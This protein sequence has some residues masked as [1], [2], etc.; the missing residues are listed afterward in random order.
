MSFKLTLPASELEPTS[1]VT[2]ESK[3]SMVILGTNGSGKTRLGSWL[4]LQSE[5]AQTVH[6][7][8]AQKS[9]TMPSVSVSMSVDEAEAN[10]IYGYKEGN[11]G[12]KIGHRWGSHPNTFLLNDFEGL[13]AY[14][15]SEE[16]DKSTRYRQTAKETGNWFVPPETRLDIIRRIWE[17]VLP[18]RRLLIGGGKIETAVSER[19][20]II[21]SAAEMS[22][23][24][25]VIFYLIGQALSAPKDGILI[26]DEPEL[27]LHKSVQ[28][29]L[30]DKIEAERPDCLFVYLTHDLDFAASR[31]N[32]TKVCL[33]SFDGQ[34]WDWYLV[35]D[36]SEI[37]EDI[38]LE[39][40]G[41]RKPVIFI[42]G[43]RSSL[44]YFFY[45]KLYPGFTVIPAGGCDGV[46]H[47]TPPQTVLPR[48]S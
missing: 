24:E 18:H 47:A 5:H 14:L 39:I 28:S 7:I 41:S 32:A 23:G 21:Y 17:Q 8:S 38:L 1:T 10:L 22:D 37:P 15:F 4:D 31:I 46:I 40:V 19:P 6:R 30:W 29:T 13:L 43:D 11:I 33:R 26:I 20:D 34:T 12:H 27:H 25:R 48:N 44:D 16:N 2:V 42:E 35:P 36:N 3:G 45:P 9:L